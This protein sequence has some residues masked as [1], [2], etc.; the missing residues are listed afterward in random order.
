MK[1]LFLS[2]G[3]V[4]GQRT[5]WGGN[6]PTVPRIED[7]DLSKYGGTWYEQLRYPTSFQDKN[8]K[9]T[10]AIYT[11]IDATSVTV[12][13]TQIQRIKNSD[14]WKLTGAIGE[15]KQVKPDT[16]PNKL[17]VAFDIG[18]KFVEWV[19]DLFS[20]EA[21]YNVM[22]TNYDDYAIVMS[23]QKLLFWKV[24]YAWILSRKRDFRNSA[25]YSQVRQMAMD[26]FGLRT[27]K[28]ILDPQADCTFSVVEKF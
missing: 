17:N 20:P 10:T 5:F 26:D 4:L 27:D 14:E 28:V 11:A 21:N 18:N 3:V 16:F 15:A 25:Q 1:L 13:N 7:F 23:C 9:C 12:N 19:I 22:A 8:G 6:C 24:E 2:I